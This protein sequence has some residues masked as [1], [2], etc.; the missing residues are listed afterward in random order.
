MPDPSDHPSV[1]RVLA[2]ATRKGIDLEVVAFDE[3]THTAQEA[4]LVLS[5]LVAP[6]RDVLGAEAA[7]A[8]AVAARGAKSH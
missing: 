5:Q 8:V 6:A 4:A 3:S 1:R 7:E 2:A